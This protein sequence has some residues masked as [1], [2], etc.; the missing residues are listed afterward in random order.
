MFPRDR[1]A[2]DFQNCLADANCDYLLALGQTVRQVS[3]D[4][5]KV[6]AF[7]G[8][9]LS[10]REHTPFTAQYGP[11][12]LAGGH[13]A[14]GR[15]LRSGLFDFNASPYAYANRD[16]GTG[17]LIQ[18]FARASCQWHGVQVYD[19]NDLRTFL[20]A[21]LPDDRAI[22]VGQTESLADS[23][24]H[25]R[26]ALAQA[27][28]HGTSYWWTELSGWIGPPEAYYDHPALLEELKRH[29]EIFR[30]HT[31]E[32]KPESAE[33]ALI[34]DERSI[35]A[36]S[37]E[38][39]LFKREVYDQLQAWSWCAA[40]F[41]VW[42]AEDVSAETMRRVKLAYVF[43]PAPSPE[44]RAKLQETLC[45]ADRTVWWA[46]HCGLLADGPMAFS[47]LTGHENPKHVSPVRRRE[48][49]TW[50]SLYGAC[51]GLDA[52]ALAGIARGAGV[53]LFGEAPLHVM[54][55]RRFFA[56]QSRDKRRVRFDMSWKNLWPDGDVGAVM[57]LKKNATVLL[58]PADLHTSA[59]AVPMATTRLVSS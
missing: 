54:K 45:T 8:Y 6:G 26:W 55:G 28:C 21:G 46:P 44:L 15:F 52:K 24:E 18:H 47:D 37:L 29:G 19:E 10:A 59:S 39:K 36:L 1:P 3:G 4:H 48:F 51:A 57:E 33:I 38:S 17:C 49:K 34:I 12:G 30:K 35:A 11:G 14:F 25:Q 5:Y 41:D 7:Y 58:A 43:A 23:I 9:T 32:A 13:H 42:L 50:T 40:P 16:L 22:S 20:V 31:A 53:K 56:L 2:A 27:L